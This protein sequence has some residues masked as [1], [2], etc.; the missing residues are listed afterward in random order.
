MQQDCTS[1]L[2]LAVAANEYKT[3]SELIKKGASFDSVRVSTKSK[4]IQG[5]ANECI[6]VCCVPRAKSQASLPNNTTKKLAP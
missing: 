2:F 3:A 1:P 5:L 4:L 6:G